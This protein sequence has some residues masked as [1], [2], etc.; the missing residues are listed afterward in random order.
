MEKLQDAPLR[1]LRYVAFSNGLLCAL[2]ELFGESS[3]D[4]PLQVGYV[5]VA[6]DGSVN[7]IAP[8]M[9][10]ESPGYFFRQP[11]INVRTVNEGD[12]QLVFYDGNRLD[13]L[14]ELRLS[15]HAKSRQVRHYTF[16]SIALARLTLAVR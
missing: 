16:A 14:E 2:V 6:I 8:P 3:Y 5:V 11:E 15:H 12:S 1:I 7:A 10:S 4:S 13:N 9:V